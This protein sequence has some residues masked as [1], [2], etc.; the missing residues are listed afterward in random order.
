MC[1][2]NHQRRK[3][4]VVETDADGFGPD[5]I[6][7]QIDVSRETFERIGRVLECLDDWRGRMNLIGPS[8]REHIWRRHIFDS[9]QLLPL[10]SP[11]A[12]IVDLGSGGGFPALPLACALHETGGHVTMVETVG[13]KARFLMAA[14]EAAGLDATVRQGRA[15]N[16]G[17]IDAGFVTARALAPL[18]KLLE[19][20]SPWLLRGSIGLFHKG[21]RWKEELTAASTKWT[22]A[23]QAIPDMSGRAGVILKMA[24][25][26][27]EQ[28]P[29]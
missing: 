8:E 29:D 28:S 7:K 26:S 9:L 17:D 1:G 15:E 24:E 16:V 4:D 3:P 11:D 27:R 12:V 22:F 5:E 23:S 10:L 20:A 14:V 19:L 18:P 2:G 25:V 6:S 21:E 13:K